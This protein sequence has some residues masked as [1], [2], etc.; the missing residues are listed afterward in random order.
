MNGIHKNTLKRLVNNF[1]G[2][3][4]DEEIVKSKTVV[5]MANDFKAGVAK[6]DTQ[7]S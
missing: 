6:D 1:E 7:N 2:F 5:E 3:S 4:R